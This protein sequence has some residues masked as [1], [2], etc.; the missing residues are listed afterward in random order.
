MFR[1]MIIGLVSILLVGVAFADA[2]NKP[3]KAAKPAA[4]PATQPAQTRAD[5]AKDTLQATVVSVS[6]AAQQRNA[7]DPDAKW[8]PIRAGQV[9]GERTLIRTGLGAKLVL[10][11]ADRSEVTVRS[12]AKIGIRDCRKEGDVAR[13]GVGL[14]YGTVKAKVN[15][16]AGPNDFRIHTPVATLSVRGS[17]GT[18]SYSAGFG[19]QFHSQQSTWNVR[20]SRGTKGVEAGASTDGN[21]TANRELSARKT[22]S[23]LADPFGVGGAEAKNVRDNANPVDPFNPVGGTDGTGLNT[24][25]GLANPVDR[26]DVPIPIPPSPPKSLTHPGN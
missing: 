5:A 3:G 14:K 26:S 2:T 18:T 1:Y 16:A 9:L 4:T 24:N 7:D 11:M 12:A 10:R 25:T 15:R 6:G 17:A 20:S 19:M 22:D 21:L 23:K 8:T 13:M